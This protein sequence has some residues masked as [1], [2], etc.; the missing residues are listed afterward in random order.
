MEIEVTRFLCFTIIIQKVI[1]KTILNS[2]FSY[3]NKT[4]KVKNKSRQ[5]E[6]VWLKFRNIKILSWKYFKFDFLKK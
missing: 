4:V 5:K 1:E 3:L 2:F 6:F